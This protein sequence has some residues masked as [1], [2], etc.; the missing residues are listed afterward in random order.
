MMTSNDRSAAIRPTDEA[1]LRA[2]LDAAWS[3]E[4]EGDLDEK[5]F[6]VVGPVLTTAECSSIANSYDDDEL[7]R[8]TVV[9]NRHGFGRGAYRYFRDPLP[10]LVEELRSLLYERLVPTADRW[11]E[12]LRSAEKHP[13]TLAEFVERSAAAG[14]ALPTPVLFCYAPGDFNCLHQDLYGDV[15]F[16]LQACVLLDEPGRDFAGGEFVLVEQRPRAQSTPMVVPLRKGC[17]AVFPCHQRPRSGRRG[18]HRAVIRHG[19]SEIRAGRRR[20]LGIIFHGART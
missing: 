9:M 2:R 20:V 6:T 15:R 5:G 14:Q 18:F 12:R 10:A 16:P 7:F 11:N 19:V 17:A 4:A 13:P 1:R 3:A 8:K